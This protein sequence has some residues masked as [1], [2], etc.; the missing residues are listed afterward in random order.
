VLACSG[1]RQEVWVPQQTANGLGAD[2]GDLD[3]LGVTGSVTT[4]RNRKSDGTRSQ[5]PGR[6]LGL[7]SP[8]TQ[9]VLNVSIG[10]KPMFSSAATIL[11]LVCWEDVKVQ[12]TQSGCK[13][14]RPSPG[15]LVVR[16]WH[17]FGD[18]PDVLPSP[19][20]LG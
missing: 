11:T 2:L 6:S 8:A 16:S 17:V 3:S 14:A 12:A 4:P 7:V 9:G 1:P 20:T 15:F 19:Q 18:L 5:L 13:R 10:C